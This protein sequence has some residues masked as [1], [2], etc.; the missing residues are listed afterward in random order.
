MTTIARNVLC[1]FLLSM[2][3]LAALNA[4]P[5]AAAPSGSGAGIAAGLQA[6]SLPSQKPLVPSVSVSAFTEVWNGDVL[7]FVW[8]DNYML[9]ELIWT[10]S[11]LAMSGAS[12]GLSW[13]S[14]FFVDGEFAAVVSSKTGVLEDSD[15]MNINYGDPGS[16][17][18]YSR[19]D[20]ALVKGETGRLDAGWRFTPDLPPVF[21]AGTERNAHKFSISP[22]IGIRYISWKWDAS[23]GYIQYPE[24]GD[25]PPYE[26]WTADREKEPIS[27]L[28]ISY[29]Q[30]ILIPNASICIRIPALAM[31]SCSFSATISPFVQCYA[32]DNHHFTNKTYHDLLEGGTF[33]EA[34]MSAAFNPLK[35]LSLYV[36]ASTSTI[37]NLRGSTAEQTGSSTSYTWSYYS[38]GDG[39]GAELLAERIRIGISAS[40]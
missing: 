15:W 3:A 16:K 9:S 2:T 14:G 39:G 23:G 32:V 25:G 11:E 36:S 37:R 4:A 35:N 28:G 30:D 31:M 21:S 24:S 22:A 19:H 40:F 5:T 27:G 34:S 1:L 38:S 26:A 29:S 12:A 20:T 17:T 10:L 8:Q 6:E 33:F 18:H 13:R 7:E